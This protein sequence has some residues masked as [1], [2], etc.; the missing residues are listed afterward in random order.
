MEDF[1]LPK[2]ALFLGFDSSTQSLKAT[3]LDS[4][5]CILTSEIVNFDSELPHYKTKDGVY[6]DS[7]IHGRIVSPTLMWVEAL[8]LI[9]QRLQDSKKVNFNKIVSVSG[10]GQQH[11]SVYWKKG[12]SDILSSLDPK[13]PLVE[14]LDQAFST[15]ESPIWM[16]C[17]TTEQCRAIENAVGGPL[18][19]SKL[20]GS[21]AYER[22]TGPQIRRIFETQY[23]VYD[24]TERISLVSSFVASILIGKYA[25]IDHTDGAGM[26]LM[27]IKQRIWSKQA[28]EATAPDLEE[29]LGKLAAAHDVAG[30]IA[31]YFVQRFQFNKE[32]LVIQWSGDNPNSLAG[33]TINRPGDLAISLGTSDTV[34][35]ITID[36]T[37]SLEGNVFPN[38]VDPESYMVMLCYKNG[39]LTREDIR[40]RCADKSWDVF[41]QY[42]KQA[43]PLNGGKLGFY[44][45]DH[46]ILPPLP[47]GYHRYT[48][49]NFKGDTLDG[50]VEHEVKDD[51]DPPSEIRALVEGQILSMRCHAERFGMP[52]PPKRIIATGGASAN[53][54]ILSTIASIFGCNVYT[55]QRPDSASAGAALRAAHG[56]LCNNNGGFVPISWMYKDKLEK[57]AFGCKLVA[58]AE[59]DGE[60]VAKYAFL[61][62][63][64]MEIENQLVQKFGRLMNLNHASTLVIVWRGSIGSGGEDFRSIRSGGG[65]ASLVN[66]HYNTI[67]L[68]PS[69][70]MPY[71]LEKEHSGHMDAIPCFKMIRWRI[72]YICWPFS[73]TSKGLDLVAICLSKYYIVQQAE[74]VASNKVIALFNE[75]GMHRICHCG[76]MGTGQTGYEISWLNKFLGYVLCLA[77]LPSLDNFGYELAWW[78]LVPLKHAINAYMD[79]L[80]EKIHAWLHPVMPTNIPPLK[81]PKHLLFING[82]NGNGV[83]ERESDER[84]RGYWDLRGNS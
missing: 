49:E 70:D 15:K 16:D 62:R 21:R 32:C 8:D 47:I 68:Q 39:S 61:V 43:P 79:W 33:L 58:T 81:S 17:S 52:S 25:C 66:I 72:S 34:F 30:L 1:A 4:N 26:N 63:K 22:F 2:D 31:P 56:W 84:E 29:K 14:Q 41:N 44:Y 73:K 24:D 76:K 55:V 7:S 42:L 50:V 59:E 82:G 48:L 28:L 40:D 20:T 64:R 13:K 10:S 3:V 45:K 46:E 27:D 77:F 83:L 38:P 74:D 53:H 12:S 80:M 54:S 51:F 57:T 60:L 5:L 67:Y 65:V 78:V 71:L 11:G 18:E 36:H 75:L 19:L 69:V 23:E 37:P 6:R 9:L 35:G